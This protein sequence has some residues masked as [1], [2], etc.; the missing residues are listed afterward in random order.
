MAAGDSWTTLVTDSVK[1][2]RTKDGERYDV[3]TD[4]IA[5]VGSSYISVVGDE[6]VLHAAQV[7]ALWQE[8]QELSWNDTRTFDAILKIANKMRQLHAAKG[9]EPSGQGA[10]F[11]VCSPGQALF[12]R[13]TPGH[14]G[15]ERQDVG[16]VLVP[17]LRAVAVYGGYE[18][19]R[20]APASSERAIDELI[21]F[22]GTVDR[23]AKTLQKYKPLP[24][25]I[26]GWSSVLL[27]GGAAPIRQRPFKTIDELLENEMEATAEIIAA[28]NKAHT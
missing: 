9:A 5:R 16:P 20:N 7:F 26:E 28:S 3:R 17:E 21:N 27:R 14:D 19:W 8:P 2:R 15:F 10:T 12:W 18:I 23:E 22:M 11:A 24:Y 4:K 25:V 13:A 1:G 6:V